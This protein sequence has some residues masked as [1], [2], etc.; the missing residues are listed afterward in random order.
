MHA[1]LINVLESLHYSNQ[2]ENIIK[3]LSVM[4][5]VLVIDASSLLLM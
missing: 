5:S 2:S 3:I 4:A 1:A